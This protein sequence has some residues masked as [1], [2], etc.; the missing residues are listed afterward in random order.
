MNADG[1]TRERVAQQASPDKSPLFGKLPEQYYGYAVQWFAYPRWTIEE[2]ANLLTGCVPHREMFLPGE[3]HHALDAEVVENENKIRAALG[4]GLKA[5]ESKRYFARTYIDS[6]NILEWATSAAIAVPNDLIKAHSATRIQNEIQ[7]Y[8]TPCMEAIEWVVEN[9][10]KGAD[11][12]DPPTRGEIV[13]ALLQQFRELTAEECEMVEHITRHPA[14]STSGIA[15]E[16]AIRQ[17]G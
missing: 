10:W 17:R 13:Q 4:D 7:G 11:L 15:Y 1:N 16:N 9:F 2:T 6:G 5:V 12:R 14:A 8:V 3:E